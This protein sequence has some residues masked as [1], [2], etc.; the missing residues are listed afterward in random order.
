MIV[1]S[2]IAAARAPELSRAIGVGIAVRQHVDE[3]KAQ[4][5]RFDCISGYLGHTCAKHT[6]CIAFA[7]VR[8]EHSA[9]S[10]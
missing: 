6:A 3:K 5:G 8:C 7:T 10:L 4:F 1:G 2:R 9:R